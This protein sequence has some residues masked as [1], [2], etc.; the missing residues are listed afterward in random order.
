MRLI[1]AAVLIIW[2]VLFIFGVL[3][4]SKPAGTFLITIDVFV[5]VFLL[6]P[7]LP[8][9]AFLCFVSTEPVVAKKKDVELQSRTTQ[10]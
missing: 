9:S 5:V 4:D 10:M 7:V 6:I 3:G 8:L 2:L 1:A